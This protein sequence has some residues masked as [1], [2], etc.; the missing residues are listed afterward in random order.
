MKFPALGV[1]IFVL[2]QGAMA[3]GFD[4]TFARLDR[5]KWQVADFD[6]SN[7]KF[8]T[9]WRAELARVDKGLVLGLQP[10]RGRPNRFAGASVRRREATGYGCYDVVM[11]PARGAGIISGF[12]IYTGPHYG[13]RHDEIDIEFLGRD[14]RKIHLALFV[15]GK[16]WNRFVD[17]GF[18]AADKPRRYGFEWGA[19]SVRWF[20]QGRLIYE[21]NVRDGPIPEVPGRVFANIWA[22]DPSIAV[23]AGVTKP[24]VFAS[25]GISQ[26][27]FK[28]A[29]GC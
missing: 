8:D 7:P 27:R 1:L 4:E 21:R 2:G 12:F 19:N 5:R 14:T 24:G 9:D 13:T 18:D 10:Q 6:F 28:A 25:S 16:H 22:A 3:Q 11:Q 20:V 26:I 17:L 29:G 23:W 15:D